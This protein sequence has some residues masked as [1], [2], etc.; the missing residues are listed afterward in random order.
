MGKTYIVVVQCHLVHQRCSGF[1]CEKAFHDRTGGFARYALE[2]ISN[3]ASERPLRFLTLT[4]G[5]CCGRAL[6]RKLSHLCKLANR[7]DGIEKAQIAVHFASC[8]SKDN[9]HA[10]PCPHLDYLKTLVERLQ[11]DWVEDSWI[12]RTAETRRQQG[13]YTSNTGTEAVV[14]SSPPRT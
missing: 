6:L 7:R 5:G 14:I 12:S 1:H 8:I 13:I 3:N 2:N 9:H 11:L 10:P 4:C